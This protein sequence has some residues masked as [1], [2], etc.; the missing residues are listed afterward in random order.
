[1]LRITMAKRPSHDDLTAFAF[2]VAVVSG[3]LAGLLALAAGGGTIGFVITAVL[4]LL[5]LAGWGYRSP[6][7]FLQTY[8]KW[9]GLAR[10]F[11]A[12]A[13]RFTMAVTFHLVFTLVSLGG[14]R[15]AKSARGADSGWGEKATP[16]LKDQLGYVAPA[17]TPEL[18]QERLRRWSRGRPSR[19]SLFLLPFLVLLDSLE[20]QAAVR[21]T[22]DIYTLY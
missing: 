11:A 1:M 2:A 8:R 13:Q 17:T 3:I 4:I 12:L 15:F 7:A 16:G 20:G 21:T 5:L 18:W 19:W 6:T 9:N 22:E 14:A 10:R